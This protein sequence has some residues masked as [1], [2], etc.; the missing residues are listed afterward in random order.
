MWKKKN[1]RVKKKKENQ[2]G[3]KTIHQKWVSLITKLNKF[4]NKKPMIFKMHYKLEN[5]I[6][7]VSNRKVWWGGGQG[8]RECRKHA[9]RE[10]GKKLE[11]RREKKTKREEKRDRDR[12][13]ETD[14][15]EIATLYAEG[16]SY[17]SELLCPASCG[18]C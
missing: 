17:L 16:R 12:Q 3:L 4:K 5:S 6:K 13:A 1:R 2:S 9:Q 10:K 18:E 8:E 14:K 7:T 11:R 15:I